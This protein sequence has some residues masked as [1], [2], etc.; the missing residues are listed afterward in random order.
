MHGLRRLPQHVGCQVSGVLSTLQDAAV[1]TGLAGLTA[2]DLMDGK[3]NPT[4]AVASGFP[5][6]LTVT[7][8]AVAGQ[9]SGMPSSRP[10]STNAFFGGAIAQG[11]PADVGSCHPNGDAQ[12]SQPGASVKQVIA[13]NR[14]TCRQEVPLNPLLLQG[15]KM[16]VD[17][18]HTQ[19]QLGIGPV[20]VSFSILRSMISADA[21]INEPTAEIFLF[22]NYIAHDLAGNAPSIIDGAVRFD[23]GLDANG[24]LSL[25]PHQLRW[26]HS[27]IWGLLSSEGAL[28]QLGWHAA[29]TP[30]HNR[31]VCQK[32]S[33]S[34]TSE[35]RYCD[36]IVPVT[37]LIPMPDA[38][39]VV[40]FDHDDTDNAAYAIQ[41]GTGQLCDVDAD[42][43]PPARGFATAAL[44][45]R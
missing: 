45:D 8:P 20:H 39:G 35:Q 29:I 27:G 9:N 12:Q 38:L 26:D 37:R 5:N 3:W 15:N 30:L 36:M 42:P 13:Y 43:V 7:W 28:G 14:G 19:K 4:T 31:W 17:A 40:F 2:Q 23:F 41:A 11:L 44:R 25:S 6:A 24:R 34:M 1:A 32:T 18:L 10:L 22:L 33:I 21:G 16:L